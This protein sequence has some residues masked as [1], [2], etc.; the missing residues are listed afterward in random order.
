MSDIS[1]SINKTNA[2]QFCKRFRIYSTADNYV[3]FT[4][5]ST[6]YFSSVDIIKTSKQNYRVIVFVAHY[7]LHKY[8]DYESFHSLADLCSYLDTLS[9]QLV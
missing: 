2:K 9:S 5:Y 3:R 6:A 4:S 8:A 7:H 1:Y